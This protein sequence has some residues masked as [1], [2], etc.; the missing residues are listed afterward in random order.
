MW[1]IPYA[2]GLVAAAGYGFPAGTGWLAVP[3]VG[4]FI[5]MGS[6]DIDCDL[7]RLQYDPSVELKD[8]EEKCLDSAID[9]VT[10]VALLT[11]SGILQI[12]GGVMTTVGLGTSESQLVRTDLAGL[13]LRPRF[14]RS[15]T[16]MTA[17]LRF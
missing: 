15:E 16:T 10:I 6:R 5:A 3:I 7:D 4:P 1:A 14:G 13:S 12:S 17:E 11:I 8:L 9:E 2:A